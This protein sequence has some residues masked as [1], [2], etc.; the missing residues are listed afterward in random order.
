MQECKPSRRNLHI[1][2]TIWSRTSLEMMMMMAKATA[3]K[4]A[5]SVENKVIVGECYLH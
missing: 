5:V 3:N 4:S 1:S 2:V